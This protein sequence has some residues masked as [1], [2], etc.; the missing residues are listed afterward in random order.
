MRRQSPAPHHYYNRHFISTFQI[1]A[2]VL[3][4]FIITWV[5]LRQRQSSNLLRGSFESPTNI[6][7][8]LLHISEI[9]DFSVINHVVIVA[10]HAVMRVS[11]LSTADTNDNG[12]YVRLYFILVVFAVTLD[13]ALSHAYSG[14]CYRTKRNVDLPK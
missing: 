11:K 10:G 2:V 6:F 3:I 13:D 8:E 4:F 12:W 9:T 1:F 5:I 14:T 7:Q